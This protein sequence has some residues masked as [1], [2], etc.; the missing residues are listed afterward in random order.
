MAPS[1]KSL[2]WLGRKATLPDGCHRDNLLGGGHGLVLAIPVEERAA[3]GN[4]ERG[5]RGRLGAQDRV[6]EAEQ[7]GGHQGARLAERGHAAG[8]EI[9]HQHLQALPQPLGRGHP[10]EQGP[11]DQLEP[12]LVEVALL[13]VEL[14]ARLILPFQ[15]RLGDSQ[16][17]EGGRV[18]VKLVGRAVPDDDRAGAR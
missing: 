3:V 5:K 11:G 14:V 7:L 10:G 18:Q 1:A 4:E 2:I 6:I 9:L 8:V 15:R 12:L 13:P 16:R 17:G